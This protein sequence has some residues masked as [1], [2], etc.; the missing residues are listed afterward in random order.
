MKYFNFH[1]NIKVIAHTG[2][3]KCDSSNIYTR[4]R[5]IAT[6]IL[7]FK[8]KCAPVGFK[9]YVCQFLRVRVTAAEMD[10]RNI[11]IRRHCCFY[12][13]L[14][15]SEFNHQWARQ[16]S[17]MRRI[18]QIQNGYMLFWT[19]PGGCDSEAMKI[20]N[21]LNNILQNLLV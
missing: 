4:M 17:N 9:Y 15:T 11:C 16:E 14:W 21:A 3:L 8:E 10:I 19:W 2:N 13:W 5:Q 18:N 7:I 20:L 12:D 6:K 1:T